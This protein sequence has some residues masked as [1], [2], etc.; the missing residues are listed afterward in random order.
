MRIASS[1]V[2]RLRNRYSWIT[3]ADRP[4]WSRHCRPCRAWQ[5]RHRRRMSTSLVSLQIPFLRSVRMPEAMGLTCC[6]RQSA[7]SG[8][9]WSLPV[10]AGE[11]PAVHG[12]LMCPRRS[13]LPPEHAA[14]LPGVSL[15]RLLPGREGRASASEARHCSDPF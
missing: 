13:S 2:L 6:I 8:S 7:V 9:V 14:V 11:R 10:R 15:Y 3:S 1:G 5:H 4:L 12:S